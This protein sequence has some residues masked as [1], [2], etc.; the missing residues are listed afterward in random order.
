LG[1][2]AAI[3]KAMHEGRRAG[4]YTSEEAKQE[5]DRTFLRPLRYRLITRN[6][7]PFGNLEPNRFLD[8]LN[9]NKDVPEMFTKVF[10]GDAQVGR[11]RDLMTTLS[12]L[13][14]APKDK[15]VFIQLAQAGQITGALAGATTAFSADSPELKYGSAIAGATVLL[16]PVALAKM[17]TN[18]TLTREFTTGLK[19]GI[20]SSRLAVAL[21][22]IGEMKAASEIARDSQSADSVDFYTAIGQ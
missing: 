21:R 4:T 15:N 12:V 7:D 11:I 14:R 13:Q 3:S 16:S 17:L 5:F 9:Q 20:R 6:V 19:E 2:K 1:D 18:P 22:K 10:G 8:M